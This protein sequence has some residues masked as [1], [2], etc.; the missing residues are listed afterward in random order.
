VRRATTLV[1][2]A[3][4]ASVAQAADVD[5]TTDIATS[6]TWTANNVYNLRAQVYVLPGAT[7]TIEAG[8]VIASSPPGSLVGDGGA[9]SL[10]V[11]RGGDIHVQGTDEAPVVFTSQRDRATWPG[12]NPLAGGTWVATANEWGNLALLGDAYIS[13]ND[14]AFGNS[15]T[16][17][18]D[19]EARMEG[20]VAPPG[21]MRVLYGGGNDDDD[22]GT[23]SYFQIRYGGDVIGLNDELNGFSIGG[24]GRGTD[25]HHF[26]IMNNVDDGAEVWGGTVNLK[27]FS[28]WNVGDDSFDCDQGWRGQAEF[29]LIVQGYS[30]NAPQGSGVGDNCF[31]TDGAEDSDWQPVTTACLYNMTV[32]G[33]PLIGDGATAWRDNARIQYRNCIFMDLGEQLVRFDNDDGDG[34]SGYGHNGTL[35]WPATW[36]TS[37]SETS[38][39]NPCSDPGEV[40]QAQLP[41]RLAEIRDSVF[42]RNLAG[43]AYTEATARGVF[44]AAN[45]NDLTPGIADADAPI[46][47]ITRGAAVTTVVG[48]ILPVT[49]LDPRPANDAL[50]R[51]DG[52]AI[53]LAPGNGF[54]TPASY[55]GAFAPGAGT[56]DDGT[57][58]RSKTWLCGWTASDA[59]G[60]TS[61]SCGGRWGAKYCISNPNS[62]GGP[63]ILTFAGSRRVVDGTAV[64]T[65]RPVPNQPGIFFHADRQINVPFGNGRLCTGGDIVRGAVVFATG[66]RATYAYDNSDAKHSLAAYVGLTR[67]FQYWFRDPAAPPAAFN[68]SDAIQLDVKP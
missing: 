55:R 60:F 49:N 27:Y 43:N 26:E 25:I 18:P 23:L 40:Y 33:Q 10:A 66:N 12:G 36:T 17:D 5:I 24:V 41:G 62:A 48:D 58:S 2:G 38:T 51:R 46:V 20:L 63:A 9:G 4:L 6:T 65:A 56:A 39:V 53:G 42:F 21:D 15:P 22:S 11:A 3:G 13:E 64:F 59:F 68:T 1:I 35:S 32:I 44:D 61:Q 50:D 37:S 29:G 52:T 57:V 34:A 14:P 67:N 47:A 31:E 28:I 30:L 54:F 7:L 19:N 45:N 16:C 8:T